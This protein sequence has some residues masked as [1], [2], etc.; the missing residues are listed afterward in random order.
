MDN[1][2]H[3]LKTWFSGTLLDTIYH[4]YFQKLLH[5]RTRD[6]QMIIKV[7]LDYLLLSGVIKGSKIKIREQADWTKLEV[8]TLATATADVKV[9]DVINSL[10]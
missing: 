5:P 10:E 3:A 9:I 4:R 8:P 6:N 1:V 2:K 7:S